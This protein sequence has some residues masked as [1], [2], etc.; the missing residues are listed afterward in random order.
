MSDYTQQMPAY[1]PPPPP[2]PPKKHH[3]F[4]WVAIGAASLIMLIVVIVLAT[5]GGKTA[6]SQTAKSSPAATKPMAPATKPAPATSAT[7]NPLT[8]VYAD[9]CKLRSAGSSESD[10][11]NLV[12]TQVGSNGVLGQSPQQIVRNAEKQDCPQYLP[13]ASTAPAMTASQQQAVQ[14]AQ[15]YL[16]LGSGFSR[17]GLIQQLTSSSGDGFANADAVFAVNY[18]HPDWNAQAVDAAK[19]YMAMG[20]FSRASL[21]QQLTSPYGDQFTQAQ[22]EYAA[23][24]VGL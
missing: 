8:A 10:I 5:G 19:G 4:R 9:V 6:S 17:A 15:G 2:Q 24:A 14:A 7:A 13:T 18:L 23:N 3:L 12:S 11:I 16:N 1:D 20:G 21:I 22:A